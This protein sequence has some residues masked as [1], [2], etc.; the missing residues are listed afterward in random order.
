MSLAASPT[1]TRAAAATERIM[2]ECVARTRRN[3]ALA[4]E[5]DALRARAFHQLADRWELAARLAELVRVPPGSDEAA[6]RSRG[7]APAA[8]PAR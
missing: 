1:V 4:R 6:E 5:I 8:G 2:A 3:G 7:R